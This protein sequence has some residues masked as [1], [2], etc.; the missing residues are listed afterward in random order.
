MTAVCQQAF[1]RF[2]KIEKNIFNFCK[3]LIDSKIYQIEWK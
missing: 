3:V 2:K 1:G